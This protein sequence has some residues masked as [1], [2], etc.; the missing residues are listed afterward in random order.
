MAGKETTMTEWLHPALVLVLGAFAVPFFK[1]NIKKI[2][3]LALPVV[4]FYGIL[5]MP[6]GVNWNY[7]Y[8]GYDLVFERVD[9]LSLIFGYVFTIMA[10]IGVTYALHLDDSRQHMAALFY[11]GSSLGVVFA[12]DYLTLFIFWEIMAFASA[13][14]VFAQRTK[15][16]ID[17][18]KRYLLVHIAG[19]LLLFTGI[20]MHFHATGSL[21]FG[22]MDG[23][24]LA[25]YL[26]MAGFMLNAAVVPLNAWV[27]DAYPEATIT[28]TVFMSIFTTKTAVY[29][30][31]RAFAG[32]EV[33]VVL[34]V[35]M[36]VYGAVYATMEN[37]C[38]RLLSHHIISQVGYMVAGVG[39]GTGL[40]LNGA[41]AHA[42]TNILY[43]GLLFMGAGAV[44]YS[45]GVRKL[46]EMG[47]LYRSM[48]AVFVLYMIGGF[49]ISAFPLFAGFVSK[50][51]IVSASTHEKYEIATLLLMLAASGTFL[52]TT[53]KLPYYMFF[54]EK[55]A[56]VHR[57]PPFNMI[58]GMGMAAVLC[59]GI[60]VFPAPLYALLPFDVHYEPY[61]AS[62]IT[63][64]L[65]IL[66][67]TAVAFFL[68]VKKV[69]ISD[70]LKLDTDWFYR[71]GSAVFMWILNRPAVRGMEIIS[72]A[73][74]ESLPNGLYYLTRNP[75]AILKIFLDECLYRV[76]G[77]E[78]S[79]GI[80]AVLR[81]DI[82]IYPR[83]TIKHWPIGSTILWVA[84]FLLVSLFVY[85]I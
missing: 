33:L 71:R 12:G 22:H 72:K 77:G 73:L 51:M 27:Q 35:I 6:E 37:D 58:V 7:S 28:G 25:Y 48:P 61:T 50:A 79:S 16:S 45:T 68:L 53:L 78:G 31:I 23:K 70:T 24:D 34:G 11:S 66:V 10:F 75:L 18:G 2:Y 38:R 39:I 64:S 17:A 85:Y 47:G 62:H 4:A 41:A 81:E 65:G 5:T 40:A 52:S 43:K 82:A 13:Y 1:G 84:I 32:E 49:S 44:I 36:T 59:I 46:S 55:K 19:G 67:F 8:L 30:L 76:G 57:K 3:L 42:F 14:L 15:A 69:K 63:G 56:E 60:G 20:I 74:F 29:V 21:A 83:D 26:V 54:G 80:R 9:R